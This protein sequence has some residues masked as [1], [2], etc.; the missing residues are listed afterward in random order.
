MQPSYREA[1]SSR[2][3]RLLVRSLPNEVEFPLLTGQSCSSKF[4]WVLRPGK[5]RQDESCPVKPQGRVHP[6]GPQEGPGGQE[7]ESHQNP[8]RTLAFLFSPPQG[9]LFTW[10]AGPPGRMWLPHSFGSSFPKR[11]TLPVSGSQVHM[12]W[13]ENLIGSP[14]VRCPA[15]VLS[16][17]ATGQV[18][19]EPRWH[20]NTPGQ[21]PGCTVL[22]MLR[23]ARTSSRLM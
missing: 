17:M 18:H 14:G 21:R 2:I 10:F 13:R 15:L 20:L 19:T 9:L 12:P 4:S 7:M 5:P 23:T 6:G 22:V 11:P 3:L 8:L 1:P 16:A